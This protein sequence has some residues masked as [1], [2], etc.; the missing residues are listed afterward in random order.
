M[1]AREKHHERRGTHKAARSPRERYERAFSLVTT[2]LIIFSLLVL[3]MAIL[4]WFGAIIT[5]NPETVRRMTAPVV[6]SAIVLLIGIFAK[7][8][9]AAFRSNQ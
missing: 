3:F 5:D 1:A 6:I 8:V 2:L 7:I 9:A 4:A